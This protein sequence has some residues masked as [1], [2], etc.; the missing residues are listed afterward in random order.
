MAKSDPVEAFF[1]GQPEPK[2][3]ELR[4]LDALIR[5]CL[6]AWPRVMAAAM[7]G[8]GPYHYRYATGREG[9]SAR[10][11]L[12]ANK[13]GISVYVAIVVGETYLPEQAGKRLGA[14]VSVGKSCIRFKRL[15]DLDLGVLEEVLRAA[16]PLKGIGEVS[17]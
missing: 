1:A 13:T 17:G 7:V 14:K 8:Y 5:A 3:A 12:A 6:P 2:Q 16:A 9:D 10:V 15:A 4:Q 11:C